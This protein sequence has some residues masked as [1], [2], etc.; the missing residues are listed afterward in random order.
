[1]PQDIYIR[2]SSLS[3]Y[4]DCLRRTAA[5][6]FANDVRTWDFE[7]R[8]LPVGVGAATGTGTH[9]AAAYMLRYKMEHGTLGNATEADQRAL[10]SFEE[11]IATGVTWDVVTPTYNIA[12]QQL[13][14]QV[15]A[16]RK[17]VAPE[18][19]P[20]AVEEYMEAQF[21]PGII[22]TGHCDVREV[23]GIR[24]TKTGIKCRAN[25]PQYGTYSMLSRACGNPVDYLIEDYVPR[26][27]MSKPQPKPEAHKYDVVEAE[28][29]AHVL[30]KRM[31][32]DL[33]EFRE[34][35]DPWAFL[36]NPMSMMCTPNYCEAWGTEFCKS[37]LGAK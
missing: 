36:A 8:E 15:K 3:S 29:A 2:A 33:A 30:I 27:R 24:D 26:A 22:V 19:Q 31:A 7:L 20:V 13:V 10:E 6:I 23:R 17:Y 11:E 21:C 12:Q 4:P 25:G 16:Y 28:R 18:I 37:H 9:S 1:M 5:R 32:D 14:R 34:T 35:G